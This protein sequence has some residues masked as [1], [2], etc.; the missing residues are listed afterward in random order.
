MT[1]ET[2]EEHTLKKLEELLSR[3]K[4]T[5]F[6]EEEVVTI[7]RMIRL[8]QGY[9]AL[10]KLA[11]FARGTVI[12]IGAMAAAYWAFQNALAEYIKHLGKVS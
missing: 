9:D 6:T 5:I 10:G 12:W 1:T 4:V 7:R 11:N 8:Y 2:P 3:H